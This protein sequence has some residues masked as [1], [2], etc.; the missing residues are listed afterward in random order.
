VRKA[1]EGEGEDENE[2]PVINPDEIFKGKK[3]KD[4]V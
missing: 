1:K 2:D 4:F 3:V